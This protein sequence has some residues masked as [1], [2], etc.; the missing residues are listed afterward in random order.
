MHSERN[1]YA[2][3][4]IP[5]CVNEHMYSFSGGDKIRSAEEIRYVRNFFG[6]CGNI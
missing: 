5:A 1:L 6:K 3:V 2:V 4:F